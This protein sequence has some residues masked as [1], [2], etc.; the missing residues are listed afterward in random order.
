MGLGQ[1][2]DERLMTV[3]IGGFRALEGVG[4]FLMFCA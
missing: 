2:K 1:Q 3:G 4:V